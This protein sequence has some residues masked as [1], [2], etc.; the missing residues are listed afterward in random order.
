MRCRNCNTSVPDTAKYCLECGQPVFPTPKAVQPIVQPQIIVKRSGLGALLAFLLLTL[1]V[2]IGVALMG[3]YRFESQKDWLG[4]E[5][6]IVEVK[7]TG[8]GVSGKVNLPTLKREQEVSKPIP[9]YSSASSVTSQNQNYYPPAQTYQQDSGIAPTPKDLIAG[10]MQIDPLSF[11]YIPFSVDEG[12]Q[13]VVV[14]KFNAW[15]GQNDI[16][17]VVLAA[18][19]MSDFQGHRAYNHYYNSGYISEGR[20]KIRLPTGD[21]FLIFNN[22]RSILTPKAVEAYIELR[23]E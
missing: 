12:H 11:R 5:K 21:Y 23:H 18:Q 10:T 19:E 9:N 22:R 7:N 16:N 13:G 15:G 4:R 1:L 17:V 14:G 8:Q 6:P 3:G 20:L 2:G